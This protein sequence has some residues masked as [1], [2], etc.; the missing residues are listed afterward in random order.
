MSLPSAVSNW[1]WMGPMAAGALRPSLAWPNRGGD[2]GSP[3]QRAINHNCFNSVNDVFRKRPLATLEPSRQ[4]YEFV[5]VFFHVTSG[6]AT[7]HSKRV[8]ALRAL[9]P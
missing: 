4:A 5:E 1:A 2:A 7:G 8:I 6:P 9:L 3:S